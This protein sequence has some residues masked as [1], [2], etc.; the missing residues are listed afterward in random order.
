MQNWMLSVLTFW[1]EF[2]DI[3]KCVF[4]IGHCKVMD[5]KTVA[6]IATEIEPY[7]SQCIWFYPLG[8]LQMFGNQ[9]VGG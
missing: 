9:M 8:V 2:L 5:K 4:P 3:S 6:K 1:G 7:L